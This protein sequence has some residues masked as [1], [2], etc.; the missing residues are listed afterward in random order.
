MVSSALGN[1]QDRR[2]RH[3]RRTAF[4]L[5]VAA[6]TVVA[7]MAAAKITQ[8]ESDIP[9]VLPKDV[10]EEWE[11]EARAAENHKAQVRKALVDTEQQAI[12]EMLRAA[13]DAVQ[14]AADA[15]KVAADAAK[16][17]ADNV[18]VMAD[19]MRQ[20]VATTQN[21]HG[22]GT[23]T[24]RLGQF[25]V[26]HLLEYSIAAVVVV[27]AW[28][29]LLLFILARNRGN[30]RATRGDTLTPRNLED[31][32]ED[33]DHASTLSGLASHLAHSQTN[34]LA[35]TAAQSDQ[36]TPTDVHVNFSAG[37]PAIPM[38]EDGDSGVAAEADDQN[39]A[40]VL[41]AAK[42]RSPIWRFA[43]WF[44][45]LGALAALSVY[46]Y[47][48]VTWIEGTIKHELALTGFEQPVRSIDTGLHA[49]SEVIEKFITR[50]GDEYV[51]ERAPNCTVVDHI[52]R[53]GVPELGKTG[54]YRIKGA[55]QGH[56]IVATRIERLR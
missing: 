55:V 27:A 54:E 9:I 50:S 19:A 29:A 30:R 13:A 38:V 26:R 48:R 21:G 4:P 32:T 12:A 15:T 47:E 14:A 24:D 16:A 10:V 51:L 35:N 7:A 43:I 6:A 33:L 18:R 40:P 45:A 52:S 41:N 22:V 17:A 36:G 49:H 28:V 56:V 44:L 3:G 23:I 37:R 31:G 1:P 34:G 42:G 39:A 2:R 11:R 20:A 25:A 53:P 5:A 8:A 46:V